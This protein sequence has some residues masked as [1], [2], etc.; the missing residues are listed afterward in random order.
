MHYESRVIKHN[1]YLPL[2]IARLCVRIIT[3]V[4]SKIKLS[5]FNQD[6]LICMHYE[7][8]VIKHNHY[9]PLITARLCARIIKAAFIKDIGT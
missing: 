4:S 3:A 1:H 8:R 5:P 7:S 2:I 6:L 9:L